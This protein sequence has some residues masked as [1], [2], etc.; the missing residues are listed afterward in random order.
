[1]KSERTRVCS[2]IL[3]VFTR[4]RQE[5]I[6]ESDDILLQMPTIHVLRDDI[7]KPQQYC[8][9]C[10]PPQFPIANN[11]CTQ[12]SGSY[13]TN[14]CIWSLDS[15]ALKSKSSSSTRAVMFG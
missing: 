14:R 11:E 8:T 3:G 10:I 7:H 12:L 13:D 6:M 9:S 15:D 5:A 1:M 2:Q 4:M